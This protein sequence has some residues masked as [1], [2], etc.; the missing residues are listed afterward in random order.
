MQYG[1][2]EWANDLLNSTKAEL[3]KIN[4]AD[5]KGKAAAAELGITEYYT[6]L[7]KALEDEIAKGNYVPEAKMPAK[8]TSDDED[9]DNDDDVAL[10]TINHYLTV[11]DYDKDNNPVFE[12]DEDTRRAIIPDFVKWQ[13]EE[14]ERRK[15]PF[16][17][18]NGRVTFDKID[19]FP[20]NKKTAYAWLNPLTGSVILDKGMNPTAEDIK[21][22]KDAGIEWQMYYNDDND[23]GEDFTPGEAYNE[24]E[25]ETPEKVVYQLIENQL[26]KQQNKNIIDSLKF[27]QYDK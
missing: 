14:K 10:D 7:I 19:D 1:S 9:F 15:L 27:G 21:K 17:T 12:S 5:D 11:Y 13:N 26:K 2:L 23:T 16:K 24:Y 3:D 25:G 6:N 20:L 18:A 4:A 22:A 8:D